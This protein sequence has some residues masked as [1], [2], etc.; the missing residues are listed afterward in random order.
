MDL[1]SAVI[2]KRA[3]SLRSLSLCRL[4]TNYE[5]VQVAVA[6]AASPRRTR[7]TAPSVADSGAERGAEERTLAA[8]SSAFSA[9]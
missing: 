6:V 5:V 1:C 3:D 4:W 2:L 8:S 9:T 7:R